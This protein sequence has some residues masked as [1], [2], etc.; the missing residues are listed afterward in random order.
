MSIFKAVLGIVTLPLDI[1]ADV[2]TMGG[3]MTDEDQ[4]YTV[5]KLGNIYKNIDEATD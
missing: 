3:A 5:K 4:P 1:A 2:V